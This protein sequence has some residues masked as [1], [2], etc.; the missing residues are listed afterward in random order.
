M[1]YKVE[2]AKFHKIEVEADSKKEAEEK[3]AI[4]DDEDILNHS[5]ENTSMTAELKFA[6]ESGLTQIK[7]EAEKKEIVLQ[8]HRY[9]I[10]QG[11]NTYWYTYLPDKLIGRRLVR[12]KK[13]EDLE[14]AI[15]AYY[16]LLETNPTLNDLF[17]LC[18]EERVERE[19][20][21]EATYTR[22]ENI[23]RKYYAHSSLGKTPI[24]TLSEREL[25]DFLIST[26]YEKRMKAKEFG[27]LRTVTTGILKYA[28]RK[29]YTNISPT[30]FFSD[31]DL[32]KKSFA[33][34]PNKG[35]KEIFTVEEIQLIKQYVENSPTV[36]NISAIL[37]AKTGMRD[38][39]CVALKWEDINFR[40]KTIH[41]H[42]TETTYKDRK[43]KKY[44]SEVV[45]TT[46][47]ENGNRNI[48]VDDETI[49]FLKLLSQMSGQ[50]DYLFF[51]DG[52]RIRGNAVRRKLERICKAIGIKYRSPHKLRRTY[53]TE[54]AK[55]GVPKSIIISQMG[56]SDYET[57]EKYYIF[58]NTELQKRQ[59]II[60]NAINY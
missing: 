50:G 57:T 16:Q 10:W 40:D 27:L 56:H 7:N 60:S 6:I 15:I 58:N 47:T 28:K 5:V 49:D 38:G 51:V 11:K 31:L 13:K 23:Y 43:T 19:I 52:N 44:V 2:F 45:D 20:I 48:V 22:Y 37:L 17:Y 26:V 36:H 4:M 42:R 59:E 1:K 55:N 41:V 8:K 30:L 34:N 39:E 54:L 33:N 9:D 18:Y 35:K 21:S 29:G 24:T 3:A 32:N 14:D 46:K 12:K 25:S 53:A